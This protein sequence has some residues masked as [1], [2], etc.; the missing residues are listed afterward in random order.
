VILSQRARF[1]TEKKRERVRYPPDNLKFHMH[2]F[3]TISI[4]LA[5]GYLPSQNPSPSRRVVGQNQ[6]PQSQSAK[7]TPNSDERGSEQNPLVIKQLPTVKTDEESA[8]EA[9]DRN[10]KA[11]NDRKL[12]EFTGNLATATYVIGAI[13]LLQLFVFGYQAIQLR[14]TVNAATEQSEDMK[15]SIQQATRS[16]V[17]MEQIAKQLEISTK[18][19]ADSTNAFITRGAMQMRAYVCVEVGSAA[20]Q[21]KANNIKF[22][23]Q[24]VMLN[25]G[26]TPAHKVRFRAKAA[27][28]AVPLPSDFAFSLPVASVG[29]SVLGPHQR[30]NMTCAVDDFVPEEQVPQIKLCNGN[31]LY[32]WGVI[33]YLDVFSQTQTTNFCQLL[34]WVDEKSVYGTYI[35]RHN[36]AT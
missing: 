20:Y 23:A 1:R 30:L 28:L 35:D 9:K 18:T 33:E 31:G 2:K 13:G 29:G 12:V 16:A 22:V 19:S 21:V 4:I 25:A 8:Q 15:R 34:T 3:L 24:T 17:A 10:D 6:Q 26:N 32:I 11:A 14:R 5:A 27:I 36:E 7:Q